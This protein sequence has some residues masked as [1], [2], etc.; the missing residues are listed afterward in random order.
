MTR[1]RTSIIEEIHKQINYG[2]RK[3]NIDKI[4]SNHTSDIVL[5][6]TIKEIMENNSS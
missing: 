3:L 1:D 2:V 6:K 5:L 4:Y